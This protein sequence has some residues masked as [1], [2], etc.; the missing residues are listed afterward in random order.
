M[1]YKRFK[2]I[3]TTYYRVILV[4]VR[5]IKGYLFPRKARLLKSIVYLYNANITLI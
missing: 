2:T 5:Y 3:T 4:R 1:S